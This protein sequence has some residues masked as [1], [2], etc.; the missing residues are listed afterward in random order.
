MNLERKLAVFDVEVGA[1]SQPLAGRVY[2]SLP[3]KMQADRLTVFYH[4][5]AFVSGS[6]DDGDRFL[7]ALIDEDASSIALAVNY[8]LATERAFPAAIDD[9]YEVLIWAKRNKKSLGWTGK[10]LFVSGVEAGANLAAVACQISHDRG[11]PEISGQILMMPMLDPS[12]SSSSMNSTSESTSSLDTL[13]IC[14]ASYRDYLPN[15]SDRMHPY[16][17][18]LQSSRLKNLPPALILSADND[19]LRDEAEEYAKHLI[20]SGVKTTVRR[21]QPI[22]LTHPNSRDECAALPQVLSEIKAFQASLV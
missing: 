9:A 6:M 1:A 7:R 2:A 15:V 17:S 16:A 21:L 14:S 13:S 8:T 22:P 19:P 20:D 4:G 11:G 12:L 10:Y 3:R 18:P 5:G